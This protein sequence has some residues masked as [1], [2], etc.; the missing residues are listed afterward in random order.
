MDFINKYPYTDFHELNLDFILSQILQLKSDISK[1]SSENVIIFNTV[2]DLKSADL[3][4]GYLAIT[5]GYY[6]T[7]DGGSACYLLTDEIPAK[8]YEIMQNGLYAELLAFDSVSLL[9]LGARSDASEDVSTILQHAINQYKKVYIP[10]GN[11]LLE[12]PVTVQTGSQIVGAGNTAWTLANATIITCA[13]NNA[14]VCNGAKNFLISD[15]TV[16][17]ADS[18]ILVNNSSFAFEIKN[19]TTRNCNIGINVDYAW[20]YTIDAVRT[21]NC[22]KG[23]VFNRATTT[24]V[25]NCVAYNDTTSGFDMG[26][27]QSTSIFNS[28]TDGSKTGFIIRQDCKGLTIDTC[29]VEGAK[30]GCYDITGSN[31]SVM[32]LNP[33][34]GIHTDM[35]DYMIK[36]TDASVT[37][38]DARIG[39]STAPASPYGVFDISN[40]ASVFALHCYLP[41]SR[42]G[43]IGNMEIIGG[44]VSGYPN[45]LPNRPTLLKEVYSV[46]TSAS[47]AGHDTSGTLT[48]LSKNSTYICTATTAG[49]GSQGSNAV[50]DIP[51]AFG[52]GMVITELRTSPIVT[53]HIDADGNLTAEN[54]SSSTINYN[55]SILTIR[56]SSGRI[57]YPV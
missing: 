40:T 5:A 43:N 24:T 26:S 38:T 41:S 16:Y 31:T 35:T 37:I 29:A 44:S 23:F 53:W 33:S 12:V 55:I 6:D 34:F 30:A 1:I 42:N 25:K 27:C 10:K 57:A 28:E 17:Q 3:L 2:A 22:D 51:N 39:S 14:F 18:A 4:P 50:I 52:S 15:L 47:I 56:S 8:H 21:E 46:K 54:G 45:L 32:M 11:Y 7:N 19:I 48:T 13:N 9:Q 20:R 36:I 49:T